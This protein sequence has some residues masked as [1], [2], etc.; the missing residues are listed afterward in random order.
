MINKC[1]CTHIFLFLSEINVNIVFGEK[2]VAF[3]KHLANFR[4]IP[5]GSDVGRMLEP[6]LHKSA[7]FHAPLNDAGR[8]GGG[9]ARLGLPQPPIP[10]CCWMQKC[11]SHPCW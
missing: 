2:G 5:S 1:V 11:S 7:N 6:N 10:P 9:R 4:E 8:G 3:E